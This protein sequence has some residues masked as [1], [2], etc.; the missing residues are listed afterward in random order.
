[1]IGVEPSKINTNN[2]IQPYYL[3]SQ[4]ELEEIKVIESE[5]MEE[6]HKQEMREND[7]KMDQEYGKWFDSELKD[8]NRQAFENDPDNYWNID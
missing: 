3:L 5:I 4:K 7:E 1:M 6:H 8:L 2:L